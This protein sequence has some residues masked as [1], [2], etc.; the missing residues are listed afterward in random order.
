MSGKPDPY[1]QMRLTAQELESEG[2][3]PDVICDAL[4]CV[5]L[6]ATNRRH[7]SEFVDEYLRSMIGAFK[8]TP[9]KRVPR[10]TAH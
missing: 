8:D 1:L 4:M 3:D 2:V 6:N 9:R 10:Q 7:G 5:G